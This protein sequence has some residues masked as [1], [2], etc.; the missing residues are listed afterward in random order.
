MMQ[1]GV[2]GFYLSVQVP[3]SICAGQPVRLVPGPRTQSVAEC[4]D[5]LRVKWRLKVPGE[6]LAP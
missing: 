5:E 4:L 3:G 1:T 2:S 6:N